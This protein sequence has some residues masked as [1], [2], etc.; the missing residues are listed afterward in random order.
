MAAPVTSHYN[1]FPETIAERQVT[2]TSMSKDPPEHK[3]SLRE[4]GEASG[5]LFPL[6]KEDPA[7]VLK[8]QRP[9]P[10]TYLPS[11]V[12]DS[13]NPYHGIETYHMP[14][15]SKEPMSIKGETTPL[16]LHQQSIIELKVAGDSPRVNLVSS[17][18][19]DDQCHDMKQVLHF[20]SSRTALLLISIFAV[21]QVWGRFVYRKQLY[22]WRPDA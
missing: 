9:C 4:I 8:V 21:V 22:E 1:L 6:T 14:S 17:A 3:T 15:N 19:D 18:D 10:T 2:I 12:G 5:R 20:R 7:E 11:S 16:T 13:G